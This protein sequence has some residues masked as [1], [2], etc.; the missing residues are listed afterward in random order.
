MASPCDSDAIWIENLFTPIPPGTTNLQQAYDNSL[1]GSKTIDLSVGPATTDGV[2]I[3][4][5][6]GNLNDPLFNVV[7]DTTRTDLLSIRS[8]GQTVIGGNSTVSLDVAS[9]ASYPIN[10]VLYV[11]KSR[12]TTFVNAI[13][14]VA[15][16]THLPFG[17]ASTD[18]NYTIL[19]TPAALST[20]PAGNAT[21]TL[22]LPSTGLA[23][24][25]IF[26]LKLLLLGASALGATRNGYYLE[27]QTVLF[28]SLTGG[29]TFITPSINE[30][31]SLPG[32]SV[33]FSYAS[34]NYSFTITNGTSDPNTINWRVV[35][36]YI[37]MNV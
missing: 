19:P 29:L 14:G 23:G 1:P 32:V 27:V 18:P 8:P 34:P 3:T 16:N 2:I 36:Q 17:S 24:S 5:A 35:E 33:S 15:P 30:T 20:A 26:G 7:N 28:P 9:G 11:N 10:D 13:S 31:S 6:A 25:P 4:N 37:A 21:F 12:G 22:T